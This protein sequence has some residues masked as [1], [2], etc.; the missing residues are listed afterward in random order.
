MRESI[1]SGTISWRFD[2]KYTGT[3]RELATATQ[4]EFLRKIADFKQATGFQI[5]RCTVRKCTLD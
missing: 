4:P 3:P 2:C 5:S 1:K